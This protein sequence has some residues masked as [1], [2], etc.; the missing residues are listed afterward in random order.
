MQDV[1]AALQTELDKGLGDPVLLVDLLEIYAADAVPGATGFDPNNALYTFALQTLTWGGNAYVCNIIS[2]SDITKSITEKVNSVTI[3][4]SNIDRQIAAIAQ[5]VQ[6]EGMMGVIRCVAP[7]VATDSLILFTGRF[8]KPTDIDKETFSITLTQDFGN[9]NITIPSNKF[10]S[11]DPEGRLPS[12]P[13]FEGIPFTAIGG[14]NTFGGSAGRSG[15]LGGILGGIIGFFLSR[16]KAVAPTTRQWSSVDGTPYGT[17]VRE[18]L[19]R[20]QV[21]LIHFVWADKG[22]HVGLLSAACR[23]PIAEIADIKSRTEGLSGPICSFEIP[24]DPP[25]I[26]LGEV[27]LANGAAAC[28]ADLARGMVFSRLAYVEGSA[29]GY[30]NGQVIPLS[31][32]VADEPPIWTAIVKGREIPV[33]D[34]SGVYGGEEWSNNPVDLWRFLRTDPK[35]G[36]M[37]PA[38]MYDPV[39]HLTA[40][41]CDSPLVDDS[42]SQVIVI[43]SADSS[44]AGSLF[45]RY[46]SSGLITPRSGRGRVT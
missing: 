20:C 33:R 23:G 11:D 9:I 28:Q 8:S 34:A 37:D 41:H 35:F 19:G 43:P 3:T 26:H 22:T 25:V 16:K 21:E 42:G 10:E 39:N 46:R 18:I 4:F 38:F 17:V 13:E 24:P 29:T 1:N 15:L 36:N 44:V 7:F 27:G 31:L 40:Q 5:T 30:Q 14:S 12:D 45:T 6:L 32:E 2:R